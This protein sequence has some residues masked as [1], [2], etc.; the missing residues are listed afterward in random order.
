ML[1][2]LAESALM[3]SPV[4]AFL[5]IA[6]G[7]LK[8]FFS[9]LSLQGWAGLIGCAVLA[10]IAFHQ[11]GEA[12]HWKKQSDQFERLYGQEKTAFDTTV[13]HY[14]AA[15][16]KAKQEDAANA[17]RVHTEQAKINED[18]AQSF[19]ARIA[20]ARATAERLREQAAAH[21]GAGGTANV[22]VISAPA[23]GPAQAPGQD[24]LSDALTATEQAIQLDELIKWVRK[25]AAVNP[26]K[27]EK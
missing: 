25:Q 15:A 24:G 5:R 16:V 14:R 3:A 26:N 11:W 21:S 10:Y 20:A 17:A 23:I 2:W 9:A 7:V 4:G 12:R 22:P 18:T 8:R 13:A 1:A 6:G 19:D 27:E